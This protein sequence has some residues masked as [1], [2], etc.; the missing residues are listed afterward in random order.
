MKK[1]K[2]VDVVVATL[3][4]PFR[5]RLQSTS[6]NARNNAKHQN[7]PL[8]VRSVIN[9]YLTNETSKDISIIAKRKE[10][11]IKERF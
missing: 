7:I 5:L 6:T 2:S 1:R 8:R 11:T 4:M 10:S 9:P 3:K